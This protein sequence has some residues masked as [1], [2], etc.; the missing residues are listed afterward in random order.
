MAADKKLTDL[1]VW[2][3]FSEVVVLEGLLRPRVREPAVAEV[4]EVCDEATEL[5]A[6]DANRV[7]LILVVLWERAKDGKE[8]KDSIV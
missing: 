7:Q 1:K 8:G 2:S 4:V 5:A 3:F 6:V